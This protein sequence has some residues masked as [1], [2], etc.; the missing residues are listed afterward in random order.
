MALDQT[1]LF[2]LNYGMYAV[3][4]FFD[5]KINAQIAN[6]LFQVSAQPA[7]LAV[8]INKNNLSHELISLS[9]VF[10]V[11]VLEIESPVEFIGLLVFMSGRDIDKFKDT[12]YRKGPSGA[13]LF[14]EHTLAH[15]ECKVVKTVDAGT[16]D[17]F[18]GKLS[19]A[20]N[21]KEGE[22]M[23]YAYYHVVKKGTTPASAPVSSEMVLRVAKE[24]SVQK[25]V[26]T[27]CNYVYDPAAGDPD[28]DIAPGT[29]FS[30][31]PDDWVCPVCGVGKESFKEAD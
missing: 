16:H 22:P 3:G 26:C 20:E 19:G 11:S 14:L 13:P 15:M 7:T 24:A 17:I 30:D 4:S 21:I 6:T 1:A 28:S 27:V 8:C 10:S 9:K 29:P 23:T 5:G 18:I 2:K 12:K 25:Y 31:L